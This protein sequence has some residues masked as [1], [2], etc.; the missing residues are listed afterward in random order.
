VKARD[1]IFDELHHIERVTIHATDDDDLPNLWISD[2]PITSKPVIAPPND[3][4]HNIPKISP[5]TNDQSSPPNSDNNITDEDTDG[6]SVD[7]AEVEKEIGLR[8][9]TVEEEHREQY[10]PKDF[11]KGPWL[12]PDN[13]LYG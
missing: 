8:E 5:S 4:H 9:A 11:E 7:K 2:L 10:A 13:Q 3:E 12:N 1:V 6:K